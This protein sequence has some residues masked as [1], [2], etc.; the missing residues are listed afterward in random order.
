MTSERRIIVS[1]E[2]IKA[3]AYECKKCGAKVCF[4]ADA[5]L[6]AAAQC[7]QCRATWIQESTSGPSP[8]PI[9]NSFVRQSLSMKL[10]LSLAKLRDPEISKT[11][12]FRVLF[13][14]EEP[15]TPSIAQRSEQAR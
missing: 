7:F 12:G 2:D 4:S 14:F 15:V 13:E 9:D 3:L 1:L 5:Q 11:L 6:E 8:V 10:A